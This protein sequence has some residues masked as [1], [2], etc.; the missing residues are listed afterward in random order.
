MDTSARDNLWALFEALAGC[1]ESESGD[2]GGARWHH[3]PYVNP[4]FCGVWDAQTTEGA[5]A[6]LDTLVEREAPLVFVWLA[7]GARPEGLTEALTHRGAVPFELDAP[8]MV[9]DLATL[10]WSALDR[11]PGGL[12]IE[13]LD[14]DSQ[15]DAFAATFTVGLEVPDWAGAS[16]AEFFRAHG[17]H[18]RPIAPYLGFLDGEPVAT[19]MLFCGGGV[20]SVYGVATVPSARGRGIGA[21]MTLAPY[22]HAFETGWERAV[23]FA[24]E[25][26]A[27]VYRR[28]G[29]V[30]TGSTISRYL[31]ARD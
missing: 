6:A 20:A 22:R 3:A 12:T 13:R 14:D 7:E 26:G 29:F 17:A 8:T 1:P 19:N 2:T 24:T 4:M 21:A 16:W 11:A 30:D 28:I 31:W 23:I 9:A 27:P 25:M 18:S 15:L 5:L 10:D